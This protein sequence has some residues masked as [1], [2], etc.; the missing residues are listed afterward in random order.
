LY[1]KLTKLYEAIEMFVCKTKKWGNSIGLLIPRQ[2][3]ARLNLQ[4]NRD[5]VVDIVEKD[6]PFKELFGSGRQK[7]IT[8]QEF[9]D[10]RKLLESKRF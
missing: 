1:G 10:T 6:N 9:L 4:E 8:R 7:K 5:V 3:A 2:E